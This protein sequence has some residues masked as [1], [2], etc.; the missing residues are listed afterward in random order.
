MSEELPGPS[1]VLVIEDSPFQAKIICSQIESHTPFKVQVAHTLADAQHLLRTRCGDFFVAVVD[2]NLPDAPHGEGAD[3]CLTWKVPAVV[4]TA[5]FNAQIRTRF[6]ERK[7]VDY[8]FKGSI[9]DMQPLLHS[10]RRVYK[11]QFLTVLVVDD[12]AAQRTYMQHLLHVQRL[13]VLEA[14]DGEDA[15]QAL[16]E[17]PE[18]Q[19]VITDYQMPGMNGLDLV[20]ELR[21][22]FSYA[23]LGIIGVSAVGSGMLSAQFLKLGA[24]DYMHK[25]FEVEEFYWR[26]NQTLDH[27]ERQKRA[28]KQNASDLGWP[29]L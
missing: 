20:R 1:T 5:S 9:L 21:S 12:A 28:A 4:L 14:Q 18:V 10:V 2:L 6:I 16:Q 3:L 27:L 25:P 15:L 22:R 26:V 17:H 13:T 8:F 24:N 19:L 23:Q 7:V 29:L 11:N